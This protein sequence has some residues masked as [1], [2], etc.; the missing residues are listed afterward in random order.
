[1]NFIQVNSLSTKDLRNLFKLRTGTPSDTHDKL[2]CERCKTIADDAE[3]EALKVLPKKL[4][5]CK[6]LLE[7]MMEEEDSVQ[8]LVSLKPEEHGISKEEYERHVKQPMDLGTIKKRLETNVYKSV[9]E[10]SKDVNRIF[11]NVLK[12]WSPGQELA[13]VSR[14][15]QTWWVNEWTSLVP[16]LM[17]MKAITDEFDKINQC[18][19]DGDDVC[20]IINNDRGDDFQEQIG[21][22]DEENMRNWSHHHS[23]DTVDDPIF[24][25]AMRGYDT[26]SF[27]FGLEVTWSLIQERQQ[28]EEEKT[29]M[30]E[31]ERIQKL[32]DEAESAGALVDTDNEGEDSEPPIDADYETDSTAEEGLHDDQSKEQLDTPE[33]KS[34]ADVT[35]TSDDLNEDVSITSA[36]SKIL[37]DVDITKNITDSTS[38]TP[39]TPIE[40]EWNCEVCSYLNPENTK[41][42]EMCN[43]RKRS[44]NGSR[45]KQRT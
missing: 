7:K 24:R 30:E 15:L 36:S 6:T 8:F 11:T 22:P 14:K 27:V 43:T 41:K 20:T 21:M 25:A 5:A 35:D 38:S 4:A 45:K 42:C 34:T 3:A 29:A 18:K 23:T 1:M 31:L 28:A 37:L 9:S 16:T 12:I 26:V 17:N 39:S 44:P 33:T 2:T 19:S 13:D 40:A 10:F 32:E